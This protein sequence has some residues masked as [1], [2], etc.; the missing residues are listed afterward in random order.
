M[1]LRSFDEVDA[2]TLFH[3]WINN[4]S[5]TVLFSHAIRY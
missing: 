1:R 2:Q 5:L 3:D 4:I